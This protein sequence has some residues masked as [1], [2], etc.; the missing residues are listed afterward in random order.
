MKVLLSLLLLL[1]LLISSC[2]YNISLVNGD[3]NETGVEAPIEKDI[4]VTATLPILP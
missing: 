3:K 2:T 4:P 1:L